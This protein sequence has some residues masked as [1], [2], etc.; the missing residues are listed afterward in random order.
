MTNRIPREFIRTA[1]LLREDE[2]R[3]EMERELK[4]VANRGKGRYRKTG[5]LTCFLLIF[6]GLT[7]LNWLINNRYDTPTWVPVT[8]THH[9]ERPGEHG[10]LYLVGRMADGRVIDIKVSPATY[11]T[12]TAGSTRQF[13]LSPRQYAHSN[14]E[15]AKLGLYVFGMFL[16]FFAAFIVAIHTW[17]KK[18]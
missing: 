17:G 16:C 14:R 15:E 8:I 7:A 13:K 11:A 1:E 10:G 2:I 9:V 4:R 18:E 5:A 12:S 6:M 3:I